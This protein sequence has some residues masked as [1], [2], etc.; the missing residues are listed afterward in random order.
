MPS[1]DKSKGFNFRLCLIYFV[2]PVAGQA[3]RIVNDIDN[4][5][6]DRLIEA[7]VACVCVCVC[8]YIYIYIHVC[9][10]VY[11]YI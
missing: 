6:I 11:I 1:M 8:I 4:L 5:F 2:F 3:K 10:C 7:R 9:V